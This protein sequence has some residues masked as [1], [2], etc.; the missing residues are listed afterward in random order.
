MYSRKNVGPWIEPYMVESFFRTLADLPWNFP[1]V[2][3]FLEY[4]FLSMKFRESVG[5]SCNFSLHSRRYHKTRSLRLISNRNVGIATKQEIF[6][7]FILCANSILYVFLD[8]FQSFCCSY[9]KISSW[10]HLYDSFIELQ[11]IVWWFN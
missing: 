4:P 8:I 3:L 5:A 10:K 11:I 6:A 9:F 2:C 1:K 7:G